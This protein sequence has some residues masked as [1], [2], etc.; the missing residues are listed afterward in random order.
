MLRTSCRALIS[1]GGMFR[2]S[3]FCLRETLQSTLLQ[4]QH[5][6]NL[7]FAGTPTTNS[8]TFHE[9]TSPSV[10]LYHVLNLDGTVANPSEEPQLPKETLLKMMESLVRLHTI[11]S[12]LLEAQRQGRISFYLTHFG[13]EGCVVGT[14]AGLEFCDEAFLQYR[15]AG[16]LI[17]RGY[18]IPEVVAQCMGNVEDVLKGRQMPIHYGS[19]RLNVHMLSSPLGTQIPHA[20]GAGYAFRLENEREPDAKK[21][22]IAF[23]LFGDGAASEGDFHAG[24]NFAATLGSH[25]LFVV[26]NNAYA[27][28][29]PVCTQYA[30][31]GV[32]ARGIAYGIPSIR[33]DGSD[34]L[35]VQ[36][37]VSRAR[38]MILATHRPVLVEAVMYRASHHSTSDDSS[39]YRPQGEMGALADILSPITRFERYLERKSL[40]SAEQR[41]RL[42]QQVRQE[43]LDELRRQESLPL[44]PVTSMHDDVYKEMTPEMKRAQKELEEHYNRNKDAYKT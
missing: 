25:T 15:E 41:Q 3:G 37:V 9:N 24:V 36:Q 39:K 38:E 7:N 17:H 1:A 34:I 26:R 2:A 11:D 28:S 16:V 42:T 10:P 12:I 18:T 29:T 5:V 6:W 20:A 32:L 8:L 21:R 23:V 33:V 13:E 4:Y 31:D 44:W 43:L 27:I 19:R 35:A 40:W 22:R 14:T 30:G